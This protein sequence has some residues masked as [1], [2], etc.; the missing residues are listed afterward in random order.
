M[1]K[2][3]PANAGATGDTGLIPRSG[4]SLGGGNDNPLCILA[5]KFQGQRSLAG[6]SP[7][8]CKESDMTECA[9]MHARR[10]KACTQILMKNQ[11]LNKQM[12]RY[13]MSL[14]WKNQYYNCTTQ[15]NLQTQCNPYQITNGIFHRIRTTTTKKINNLYGSTKD[16]K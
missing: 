1:V 15:S 11:R 8:V 6:Y 14:G 16:S 9:Q 12:E 4:R 3:L 2:N 10:Q 13:T 5:W 7:W